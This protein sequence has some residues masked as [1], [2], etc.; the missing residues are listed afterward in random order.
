MINRGRKASDFESLRELV[1]SFK[2]CLPVRIVV[3]LNEQNVNSLLSAAVLAKEYV[4]AHKI[5]FLSVSAYMPH[6]AS[7][8]KVIF[9]CFLAQ[10]KKKGS[11]FTATI[12]CMSLQ[13]VWP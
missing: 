11:V 6:S 10:T 9:L 5:A 7:P 12:L 2:K 8:N 4:L 3:Y 1:G 13:T